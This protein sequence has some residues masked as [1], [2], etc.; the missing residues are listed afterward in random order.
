VNDN[1]DLTQRNSL[2]QDERLEIVPKSGASY[3]CWRLPKGGP[4]EGARGRRGGT[5]AGILLL[6][7][8]LA[9]CGAD[10]GSGGDSGNG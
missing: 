9:G 2:L 7:M 8:V 3:R 1:M 10:A 4:R 6:T 5:L